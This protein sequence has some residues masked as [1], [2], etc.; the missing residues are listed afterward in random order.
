MKALGVCQGR[1]RLAN[2]RKEGVSQGEVET[3]ERSKIMGSLI[4]QD[5]RFKLDFKCTGKPLQVLRQQR[6]M[7]W[8]LH[9][10]R[11][12]PATVWRNNWREEGK[13]TGRAAYNLL[14]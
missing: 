12:L 7:I 14:Q 2:Q 4:D 9:F 8:F 3:T 5:K 11:L 10:K 1:T 6:D 13:E